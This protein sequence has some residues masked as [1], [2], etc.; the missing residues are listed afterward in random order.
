MTNEDF[1]ELMEFNTLD[2]SDGCE[3]RRLITW[4]YDNL[5][6]LDYVIQSEHFS[7]A[8]EKEVVAQLDWYR[9]NFKIDIVE[10]QIAYTKESKVLVDL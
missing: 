5:E 3:S 2:Q 10:E 8:L 9:N 6:G 1:E 4:L 7:E